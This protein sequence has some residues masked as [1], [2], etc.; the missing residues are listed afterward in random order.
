MDGSNG[1]EFMDIKV[2][3]KVTG[4]TLDYA[5]EHVYW[6]E[7]VHQIK[8]MNYN[9]TV[10]YRIFTN[11]RVCIIQIYIQFIYIVVK[12]KIYLFDLLKQVTCCGLHPVFLPV[13]Q[14]VQMNLIFSG[15]EH[16]LFLSCNSEKVNE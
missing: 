1:N 14:E 13:L 6:A 16:V 15:N 12:Y 2:D 3:S 11:L 5:N 10:H 7:Q 4:L 9:G 8:R